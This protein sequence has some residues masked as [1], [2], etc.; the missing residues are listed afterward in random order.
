MAGYKRI[1][2]QP[3]LL[4]LALCAYERVRQAPLDALPEHS[5]EPPRRPVHEVGWEPVVVPRREGEEDHAVF[6]RVERAERIPERWNGT[7]RVHG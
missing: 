5:L 4:A 1:D 3:K 2:T 6:E 7:N